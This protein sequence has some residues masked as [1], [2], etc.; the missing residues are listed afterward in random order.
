MIEIYKVTLSN[1]EKLSITNLKLNDLIREVK[2][3]LLR[4]KLTIAIYRSEKN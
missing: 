1:D 3:N 2:K 4:R